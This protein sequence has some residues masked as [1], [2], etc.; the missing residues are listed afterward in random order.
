MTKYA[1]SGYCEELT[2]LG[3]FNG[4]YKKGLREGYGS[5]KN[6]FMIYEGYFENNKFNGSGRLDF[7]EMGKKNGGKI[8]RRK[9]RGE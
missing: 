1:K 3:Y 4:Y 8:F 2:D 5:L 9:F 7:F 6:E